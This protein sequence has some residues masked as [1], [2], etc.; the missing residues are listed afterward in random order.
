MRST[1]QMTNKIRPDLE[2]KL[3]PYVTRA[4]YF[5]PLTLTVDV[6]DCCM[7]P[8]GDDVIQIRTVCEC[9]DRGSGAQDPS[10]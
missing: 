3:Q 9:E 8:F 7:L 4:I 2:Q 5:I 10:P 6:S 1:P